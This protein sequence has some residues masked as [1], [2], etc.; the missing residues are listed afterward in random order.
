VRITVVARA[1]HREKPATAGGACDATTV[2][3]VSWAGGPA[4][5]LSADPAWQCYRYRSITLTI[6]LKNVI[7]GGQA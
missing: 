4:I 5:D 7:F 6:P 2:A 1:P 3:P